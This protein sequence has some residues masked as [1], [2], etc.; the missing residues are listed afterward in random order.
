MESEDVALLTGELASIPELQR[1]NLAF[2]GGAALPS[3]A[4]S[5]RV[6]VS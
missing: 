4:M 6:R 5:S 1:G 2:Q 3:P